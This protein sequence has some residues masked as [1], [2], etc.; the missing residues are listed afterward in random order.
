MVSSAIVYRVVGSWILE[1]EIVFPVT[2][3]VLIR[4]GH[5]R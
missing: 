5:A 2:A 1:I 4:R 3:A